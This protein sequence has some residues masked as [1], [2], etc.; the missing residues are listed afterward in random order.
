MERV[1]L[2][3]LCPGNRDVTCLITCSYHTKY[4][5]LPFITIPILSITRS[6]CEG[7]IQISQ[8]QSRVSKTS[9][10][11]SADLQAVKF[12]S[13]LVSVLAMELEFCHYWKL[14]LNRTFED[15]PGKSKQNSENVSDMK[16]YD[17]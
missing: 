17:V 2:M 15:L 1:G 10:V 4:I 3:L 12:S 9:L 8:V 6:S 16:F 13:S 14:I 7:G 11:I 5:K